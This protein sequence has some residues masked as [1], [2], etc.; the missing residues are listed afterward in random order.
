[1]GHVPA[2]PPLTDGT[3]TLRPSA[4]DDLPAIDAL[5]HDLDVVRWVG[6]PEGDAEEVL[7]LNERRW[8][9]GSPTLS[10]CD[11]DGHCVGLIWINVRE[12][13][14]PTGWVGYALLPRARGRGIATAAVRLICGWARRDLGISRLRLTTEPGNVRSRR[15]AER[16]G[17]RQTAILERSATVGDRT[18]D[19]IVYE[20][21][22]DPPEW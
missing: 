19:R 15:V 5:I 3:V 17:F 7:A 12:D 2:D 11:G 1:M 4:A 6:P 16:S 18:A 14:G 9:A 13:D 8:A 21:S 22:N 10:I 20:M